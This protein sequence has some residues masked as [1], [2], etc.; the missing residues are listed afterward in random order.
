MPESKEIGRI[1]GGMFILILI[2]LFFAAH[3]GSNEMM[4][5]TLGFVFIII[6][7]FSYGFWSA[8]NKGE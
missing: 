3:G 2:I 4:Y 8:V 1:G 6:A 5:L 7:L